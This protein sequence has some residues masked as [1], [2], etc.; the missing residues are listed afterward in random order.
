MLHSPIHP[1]WTCFLR[2]GANTSTHGA[3]IILRSITPLL[4]WSRHSVTFTDWSHYQEAG[5]RFGTD[6]VYVCLLVN[7]LTSPY[8]VPHAPCLKQNY[9]IWV[10]S[11]TASFHQPLSSKTVVLQNLNCNFPPRAKYVPQMFLK[12]NPILTHKHRHFSL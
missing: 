6:T 2:T 8:R 11:N 1:V 7:S 10:V 9:T 3:W 5:Q 4:P 12:K